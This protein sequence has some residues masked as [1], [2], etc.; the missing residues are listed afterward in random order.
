MIIESL[1]LLFLF[2]DILW[3]GSR[4]DPGKILFPPIGRSKTVVFD[5]VPNDV[6]KDKGILNAAERLLNLVANLSY[7]SVPV[8]DISQITRNQLNKCL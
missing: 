8:L 3:V 5:F 6:E 4:W 2:Q 7:F 1:F